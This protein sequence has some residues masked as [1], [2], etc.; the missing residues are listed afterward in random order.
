MP[1]W[2]PEQFIDLIEIENSK[3]YFVQVH[4][5]CFVYLNQSKQEKIELKFISKL[6][7]RWMNISHSNKFAP[8][9]FNLCKIYFFGSTSMDGRRKSS[10]FQWIK[11]EKRTHKEQNEENIH[12][13]S[14]GSDASTYVLLC[15]L[16]MVND[17]T[18]VISMPL[19]IFIGVAAAAS[20]WMSERNSLFCAI[21]WKMHAKMKS[22]Y[23]Y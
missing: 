3:V 17:A 1:P 7:L 11:E 5:K 9:R 12:W 2:A 19:H 8:N 14:F 4:S 13:Q 23:T 20:E 6:H 15:H 16:S 10:A 22:N 21:E 18:T